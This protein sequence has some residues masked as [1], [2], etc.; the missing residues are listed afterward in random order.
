M[1]IS[2]APGGSFGA[3]ASAGT[4]L[5]LGLATAGTALGVGEADEWSA[6]VVDWAAGVLAGP[7]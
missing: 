7:E 4:G 5:A 2:G 1:G 6:E 3:V